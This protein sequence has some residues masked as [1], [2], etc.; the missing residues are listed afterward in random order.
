MILTELTEVDWSRYEEEA[1]LAIED[2]VRH[3][4]EGQK[5][6]ARAPIIQVALWTDPQVRLSVVGFETLQHACECGLLAPRFASSPDPI[7]TVALCDSADFDFREYHCVYHPCLLPLLMLNF[8]EE[9]VDRL[10]R[11]EVSSHLIRVKE[12]IVASG[13]LLQLPSA[14]RIRCGVSSGDDRYD[15]Y[16]VL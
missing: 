1:V 10:V 7:D 4:A 6:S 13:C 3:Y 8:E 15:S 12:H 9:E 11:V 2:A 14:G 5:G 16:V